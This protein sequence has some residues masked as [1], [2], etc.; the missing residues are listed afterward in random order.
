MHSTEAQS[1]RGTDLDRPSGALLLLWQLDLVGVL[2]EAPSVRLAAMAV[3]V[4][5]P[6]ATAVAAATGPA[7]ALERR[8]AGTVL[9][10]AEVGHLEVLANPPHHTPHNHSA[11]RLVCLKLQAGPPKNDATKTSSMSCSP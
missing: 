5:H 3:Q 4:L 2:A 7:A 11:A 1:D 10:A 8:A 6:T 9:G